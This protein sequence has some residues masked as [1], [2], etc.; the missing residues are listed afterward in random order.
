MIDF[1][2][3]GVCA[4]FVSNSRNKSVKRDGGT[5]MLLSIRPTTILHQEF[6]ILVIQ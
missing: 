2:D 5:K 3:A 4:V 1:A 6:E